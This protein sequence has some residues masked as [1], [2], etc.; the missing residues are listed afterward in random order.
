[1][2]WLEAQNSLWDWLHKSGF[3]RARLQPCQHRVYK[4]I[5][6]SGPEGWGSAGKKHPSAAKATYLD[7]ARTARLKP[8]PFKIISA[9]DKFEGFLDWEFESKTAFP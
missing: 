2:N 4:S 6:P 9:A 1:M 3:E 5:G 8:C 7:M